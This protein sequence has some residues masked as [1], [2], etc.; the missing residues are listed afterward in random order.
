MAVGVSDQ[1]AP[2]K[3]PFSAGSSRPRLVVPENACDCHMHIYDGRVPSAADASLHPP[4][5]SVDD[6]RKLQRRLGTTRTVVVTPSTYGIDNRVML[7]ALEEMGASARGVA[8]VDAS[9]SDH[10]LQLLDRSGVRGIRFNLSLSQV[11]TI[12][13]LELLAQRVAELGW[14]VQLLMAPAQLVGIEA[15]LARTRATRWYSITSDAFHLP[16]ARN[17][18]VRTSLPASSSAVGHG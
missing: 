12:D 7:R 16:K 6:Y 17:T 15:L 13:M 14:H 4:D 2:G 9:V 8:V 11:A 18:R 10:E 1:F 3:V 5:A